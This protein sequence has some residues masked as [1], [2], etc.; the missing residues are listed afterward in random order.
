MCCVVLCDRSV[1][2]QMCNFQTDYHVL[3]YLL[4][5]VLS[6]ALTALDKAEKEAKSNKS[7]ESEK[8]KEKD[9]VPHVVSS[10][11]LASQAQSSKSLSSMW[12][13]R[14]KADQTTLEIEAARLY[15][16]MG[17]TE[18][19]RELTKVFGT[20][21]HKTHGLAVRVLWIVVLA[22]C[23]D[24]DVAATQFA[25][26]TGLYCSGSRFHIHVKY[27]ASTFMLCLF[28]LSSPLL[29]SSSYRVAGV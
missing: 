24:V 21:D 23:S 16:M 12:A 25:S 4:Q 5:D 2:L 14:L 8:E 17:G 6:E 22:K 1:D 10:A 15:A 20:D 26:Y 18:F 13:Q 19:M 9:A 27:A 28:L 7:G 3:R 11:Q 29:L